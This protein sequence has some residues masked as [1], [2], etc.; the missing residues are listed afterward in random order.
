MPG[1]L[2]GKV[3]IITGSGRGIGRVSAQR[4]AEEGAYVVVSDLNASNAEETTESIRR[5]GGRALCLPADVTDSTQMDALVDRVVEEFGRLDVMWCNAG[6]AL[7][8]P[9]EDV[10]DEKLREVLALNL[11]GVF[12]GV[13]SALRV[14]VPQRTGCLLITTSGAGLGAVRGLTAYGM[15]KAGVINLAKSVAHEYGPSGIRANVVSPGPIESEGFLAYLDSVEGLR[16]KMEGG[17]PA[18]RLGRPEDIANAGVYLASDEASFVSGIV[19][20]VD[21]GI[22]ARYPTPEPDDA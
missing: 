7:P 17:V 10:T 1:R 5:S 16:A 21:G 3:A 22:S 4:F 9:T 13:R 14:M 12:F 8:E 19:V 6:G 15:A 20:P 11:D 18:R 2:D